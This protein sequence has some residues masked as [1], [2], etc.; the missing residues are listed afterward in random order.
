MPELLLLFRST[1][2]FL[3]LLLEAHNHFQDNG[4]KSAQADDGD[5]DTVKNRI[6]GP[7]ANSLPTRMAYI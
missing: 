1:A 6:S 5:E 2:V 3:F 4:Y 7:G